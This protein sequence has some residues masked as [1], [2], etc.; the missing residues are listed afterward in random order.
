[1]KVWY[2]N[3]KCEPKTYRSNDETISDICNYI[4]DSYLE[5]NTSYKLHMHYPQFPESLSSFLTEKVSFFLIL[6]ISDMK[7]SIL[8]LSKTASK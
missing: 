6:D 1:M 3:D 4:S 8:F 5:V 7:I 2:P